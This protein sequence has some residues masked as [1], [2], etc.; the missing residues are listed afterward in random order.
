V[1][2]G[3]VMHMASAVL[4]AIRLTLV[5]LLL[6]SKGVQMNAFS[7]MYYVAPVC[8]VGLLA[9]CVMLEVRQVLVRGTQQVPPYGPALASCLLAY[10]E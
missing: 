5:Q 7:T 2:L 4:E 1:A 3:V 6:H 10:G 8:F 9:P